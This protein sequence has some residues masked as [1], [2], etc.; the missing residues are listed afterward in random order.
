M[1]PKYN[2]ANSMH[3]ATL[4]ISMADG[5]ALQFGSGRMKRPYM[6]GLDQRYVATAKYVTQVEV[7]S[8]SDD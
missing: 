8:V 2:V 5:L 3:V 6:R 7:P 1:N 4:V